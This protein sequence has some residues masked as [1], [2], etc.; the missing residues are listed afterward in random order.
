[1][2]QTEIRYAVLFDA[3]SLP[4]GGRVRRSSSPA[5]AGPPLGC[6]LLGDGFMCNYIARNY[7]RIRAGLAVI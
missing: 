2:Q 6:T 7:I 1:M 5:L 4:C 3:G